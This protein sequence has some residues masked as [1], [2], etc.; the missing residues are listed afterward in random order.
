MDITS[1]PAQRATSV[2]PASGATGSK[3]AALSSDFETFLKMLTVQMQNQD[4]LNPADA[5]DFA[6]QLASFSTVEQQVRTNE[7]LTSLG[8]RLSGQS[9][10]Q[11]AGWV[12]MNARAEMPVAYDGRPVSL[13]YATPEGTD[14]ARLVVRNARGAIIHQQDAPA[15]GGPLVWSG[16]D[17]MGQPLPTGLY[18]IEVD[19]F[20]GDTLLE[21]RPVQSSARIVE[22]RLG[23]QGESTLLIMEGGQQI[24]SG[25]VLGLRAAP[26][27]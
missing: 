1:S 15:A 17:E 5:S 7:I 10:G 14:L 9:M 6:V 3:A 16:I 18:S 8:D 12:G 26:T 22:A 21:S 24:S 19:S 13:D 27:D 20:Q 11:L 23:T 25:E 4:P 2:S